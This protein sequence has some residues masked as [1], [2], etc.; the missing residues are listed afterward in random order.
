MFG[1]FPKFYCYFHFAISPY[2][3]TLFNYPAQIARLVWVQT[4]FKT[5]RLTN[6]KFYWLLLAL[7]KT[8]NVRAWFSNSQTNIQVIWYTKYSYLKLLNV[9]YSKT[10][11]ASESSIVSNSSSSSSGL[12]RSTA[13]LSG[14][15][16]WFID[17]ENIWN[18]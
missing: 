15:I 12:L 11:H 13:N 4:Y 8:L 18:N 14:L 6:V 7:I 2:L 1:I 9:F 10:V 3:Y 5:E 17:F 16:I